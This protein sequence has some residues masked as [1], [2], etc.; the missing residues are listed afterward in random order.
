MDDAYWSRLTVAFGAEGQLFR[1]PSPGPVT[2]ADD[3]E[4]AEMR[5]TLEPV[6]TSLLT[7]DEL[8]SLSLHRDVDNPQLVWVQLTACGEQF[9]TTLGGADLEEVAARLADHLAD[10]ICETRFA[11][12]EQRRPGGHA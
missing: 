4:L 11:W 10:W 2:D 3:S 8:E 1:P 5:L 6:V 7:A 9:L 12:G